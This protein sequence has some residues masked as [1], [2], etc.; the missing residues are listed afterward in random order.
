[1]SPGS[2]KAVVPREGLIHL[3]RV[4]LL[5]LTCRQWRCQERGGPWNW[6]LQACSHVARPAPAGH[7]AGGALSEPPLE[8]VR[9][10]PALSLVK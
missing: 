3:T 9:A 1:M 10:T 8:P 2:P 4:G 6:A 7:L 5:W